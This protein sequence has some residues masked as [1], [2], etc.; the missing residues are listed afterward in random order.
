MV[1]TILSEL[2]VNFWMRNEEKEIEKM[3]EEDYEVCEHGTPDN[4]KCEECMGEQAYWES[5]EEGYEY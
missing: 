5:A 4:I 2:W 3:S 1:W